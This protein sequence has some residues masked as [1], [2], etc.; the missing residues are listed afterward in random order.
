MAP[1]GNQVNI[2]ELGSGEVC[3]GNATEIGDTGESPAKSYLFL[4]TVT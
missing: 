2:P 3:S 1:K 4:L